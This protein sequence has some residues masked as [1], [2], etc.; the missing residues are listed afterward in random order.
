MKIAIPTHRRSDTINK[1]TL[2]LLTEFDKKDIHLFISDEADMS[3]YMEVCPDYNLV[4]CGTDNA[5]DKFNYIQNYFDVGVFVIVI[6][7]DIKQIQSLMTK[8]L[9][10]LFS[11]IVNYCN[12]KKINSFGVYPSSN[13]FFMSKT[14]DIG[15]TYIV[16]N[17]F[18]FRSNK[19][20]RVL[21]Q[22]KT[23]TDYE[24]S[25]KYYKYMG[26]IARFNFISCLTNNYKNQ[27]GMQDIA[28]RASLERQASLM[29]CKLYPDIFSIN[30]NRKSQYTE[31][32]MVK[33]V[34]KEQL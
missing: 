27:G 7:D 26:N 24:R 20:H 13:K 32:Q 8:N 16:A 29:L 22:L 21:C 17:L 2:S 3:K 25:V 34:V 9:Q 6:E 11:F 33:N 28:D 15:A 18:G 19:D 30:A 5:T 1:L 4:L 12:N 31:I 10:K 14:I 23:K